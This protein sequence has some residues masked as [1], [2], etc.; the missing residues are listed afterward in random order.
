MDA[1]GDAPTSPLTM[2]PAPAVTPADADTAKLADAPTDW[3][4]A[5]EELYRIAAKTT[6]AKT[7]RVPCMA[8]AMIG[9]ARNRVCPLWNIWRRFGR[10]SMPPWMG[11]DNAPVLYSADLCW[12]ERLA[13]L[14]PAHIIAA[15]VKVM[16][17]AGATVVQTTSHGFPGAGLTAVLILSESHAVLHT[18]PE[19]GAV[20]LD[21]FS[22]STRLKSL[23]AVNE[24]SQF[25]G[26]RQ[27]T[28]QEI[29]RVNGPTTDRPLQA[30]A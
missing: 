7:P 27:V 23:E 6:P 1:V 29:A 2:V 11:S 30:T 14:E 28:L 13:A 5:V 15:F 9:R 24:L 4:E 12:C 22:C 25:F 16:E 19:S 26:A 18:W 20:N 17:H 10:A 3:A 8:I 21:I